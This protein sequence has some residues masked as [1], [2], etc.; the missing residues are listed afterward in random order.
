MIVIHYATPSLLV[1]PPPLR[2]FN[3]AYNPLHRVLV[4]LATGTVLP[5]SASHKLRSLHPDMSTTG[6]TDAY[7]GFVQTLDLPPLEALWPLTVVQQATA[8][9]AAPTGCT[10]PTTLDRA[11]EGIRLEL[12]WR[13]PTCV[14]CAPRASN[15]DRTPPSASHRKRH[16]QQD[17]CDAD[18]AE[19]WIATMCQKFTKT[20]SKPLYAVQATQAAPVSNAAASILA[21]LVAASKDARTVLAHAHPEKVLAP[22]YVQDPTLRHQGFHTA[23]PV[24][25]TLAVRSA[26]YPLLHHD[27]PSSV[28]R[29]AIVTY[30]VRQYLEEWGPK[31]TSAPI[32]ERRELMEMGNDSST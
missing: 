19:E 5:A 32:I 7:T 9:R 23:F 10:V 18:P 2:P 3:V 22:E 21:Q 8:S 31:A 4:D 25:T 17:T 20:P 29:Y 30:L 15:T 6:F 26:V 27:P 12:G 13:C 14:K 24:T 1:H 16:I 28:S 11:V